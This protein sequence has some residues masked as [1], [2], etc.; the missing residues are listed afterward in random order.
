MP[1]AKAAR[2]QI[3]GTF[4]LVSQTRLR[5][6]KEDIHPPHVAPAL[7]SRLMHLE[8][9]ESSSLLVSLE[10]Y[11]GD[12]HVLLIFDNAEQVLPAAP[13]LAGLL[14]AYPRITLSVTSRE[15]LRLRTEPV[16]QLSPLAVPDPW[17]LAPL[18]ALSQVPSATL[19]LQ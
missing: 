15:P 13:Q 19:F 11:L 4:G 1:T 14:T 7:H 17:R 16:F 18:D 12:R 10:D 2:V 9:S 3:D 6:L 5:V 8:V